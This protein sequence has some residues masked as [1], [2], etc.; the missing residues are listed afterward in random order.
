M[1]QLIPLVGVICSARTLVLDAIICTTQDFLN[2]LILN[3]DNSLCA[4]R[5]AH[6]TDRAAC[7]ARSSN[8]LQRFLVHHGLPPKVLAANK[9]LESVQFYV[10]VV[11]DENIDQWIRDRWGINPAHAECRVGAM[12]RQ[13]LEKTMESARWAASVEL[14]T[15]LRANGGELFSYILLLSNLLIMARHSEAREAVYPYD[16]A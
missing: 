15:Q 8:N 16:A 1:I 14:L 5:R 12:L 6:P 9:H 3:S 13:R 11:A 7:V 2:E 10:R 4:N